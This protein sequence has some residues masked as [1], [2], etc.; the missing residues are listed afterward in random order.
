MALL[1]RTDDPQPPAPPAQTP[2]RRLVLLALMC[3]VLGGLGG[4][5]AATATRS[6]P[7]AARF[8]PPREAAFDFSLRDQDG[9][10]VSLADARG[11]VIALTFIYTSC[12]DLCP[13]EGYDMA[14]AMDMAG[15][16][17]VSYIV[18]VD[19]VG[20][21]PAR[22]ADW[23]RR[24][25]MTNRGHYLLG[26]RDELK[27]VWVHYGIAPMNATRQEALEA[28]AG[29][30]A[31]R[32]ANPN[33]PKVPF[34][35]EPPP[36]PTTAHGGADDP[37]PDPSDLKYRGKARHI[38]GWDFEHSAYVLLIDKR[39][40]QRIGVPFEALEPESLARDMRLLLS[41]PA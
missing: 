21:T 7:P 9:K 1:D 10:R 2:L 38:Q 14:D 37:Y 12:R 15:D 16:G 39:G 30:D 3:L 4:V 23:L 13:A 11:K 40:Q 19:P 8:I 32:K 41:E 20:D 22:A 29:A 25:R 6:D 34:E 17:V 36:Q 31:F 28:A 24:R 5:L 33:P 35:Y 27:P 18:S 26:S